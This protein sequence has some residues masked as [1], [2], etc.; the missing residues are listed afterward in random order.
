MR[1]DINLLI[2]LIKLAESDN[3]LRE[4]EYEFLLQ[5]ANFLRVEKN[6][7]DTLFVEHIEFKP[8]V[9]E[10]DRILQFYRLILLS[11][12]DLEFGFDE[13]TFLR[14]AGMRLGLNPDSIECVI[15]ETKKH[16]NGIIPAKRLLEIFKVYHN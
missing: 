8:P 13:L 5:C 2:Q 3:K 9:F 15:A 16:S 10:S 4:S 1:E 7:F 12:V 6:E 14:S 11:N